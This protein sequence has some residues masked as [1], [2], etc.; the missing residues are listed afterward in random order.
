MISRRRKAERCS[1]VKVVERIEEGARLLVRLL[2]SK[3]GILVERPLARAAERGAKAPAPHVLGDRQQPGAR[4]L[5]LRASQHRAVGVDERRLGDVLGVLAV[6]ERAQR[7]PVDVAAMPAVELL[8]GAFRIGTGVTGSPRR[9]DHETS[10]RAK[11]GAGQPDSAR[12]FAAFN[13]LRRTSP[14]NGRIT[15]Q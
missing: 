13:Q 15:S 12:R 6:A 7:G 10:E 2:R 11:R 14:L 5:G 1:A 9:H 4:R 8:E 3:R